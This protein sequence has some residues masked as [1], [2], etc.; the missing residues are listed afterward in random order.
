MTV[1]KLP[2]ALQPQIQSVFSDSSE[3]EKLSSFSVKIKQ[4]DRLGTAT[5][6]SEVSQVLIG[7]GRL[8]A[9]PLTLSQPLGHVLNPHTHT[10]RI[11]SL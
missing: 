2:V 7:C 10:V 5:L 8:R 4:L 3:V 11:M 6:N 1:Q 9:M